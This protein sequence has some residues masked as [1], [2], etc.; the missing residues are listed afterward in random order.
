MSSVAHTTSASSAKSMTLIPV[1][2]SYVGNRQTWH[3]TWV[4]LPAN[5][6]RC[7]ILS[8]LRESIFLPRI[9]PTC[10]SDSR[11]SFAIG[12]L[13]PFSVLSVHGIKSIAYVNDNQRAESFTL[14]SSSSC[15]SGNATLKNH[16]LR[17]LP[18]CI[19]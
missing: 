6:E 4:V 13:E 10:H 8:L 16:F 7:H 14:T 18:H 3:S 19:Q 12:S 1:G 11:L 2:R 17:N 9:S 15:S 5:P